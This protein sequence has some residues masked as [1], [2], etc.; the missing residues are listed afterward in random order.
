MYLN[1]AIQKRQQLLEKAK[2]MENWYLEQSHGTRELIWFE[3]KKAIE[4]VIE[5][6]YTE[7]HKYNDA[8]EK[9]IKQFEI[10][11]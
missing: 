10:E 4:K 2:A 1:H 9:D 3:M 5:E 7:W 6:V 8:I 11:V